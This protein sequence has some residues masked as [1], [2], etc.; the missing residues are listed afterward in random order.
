M[1]LTYRWVSAPE[2]IER[3]TITFLTT[4]AA[5]GIII[6]KGASI[7]AAEVGCQGEIGVATAMAS[8]GLCAVR[9]GSPAQVLQAAEAGLEHSL[10][11][12]CDPI[13]GYVQIPCIERNA[14]GATKA[15]TTALLSM[16]QE[17]QG[18][19]SLDECVYAMLL[20][21]YVM[22]AGLRET[23]EYGLAAAHVGL[24]AC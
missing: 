20:T 19:V 16:F 18:I 7:S 23:S 10:G 22:D 11:L 9:G 1:L 4:A 8:A 15:I 6:K 24:T 21:G 5:I 17:G 12:T 3:D 14:T 13:M 2:E